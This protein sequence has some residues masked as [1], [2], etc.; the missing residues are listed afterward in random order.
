MAKE[1]KI[2]RKLTNLAGKVDA[3]PYSYSPN[4]VL[5]Q[6]ALPL[7][8]ILAIATRLMM[9]GQAIQ[10]QNTNESRTIMDL[11]K[12]QFILRIDSVLEN[13]EEDSYINRFPEFKEVQWSRGWPNDDKFQKLCSAGMALSDINSMKMD[14]Y[15]EALTYQPDTGEDDEMTFQLSLYDPVVQKDTPQPE[16]LHSECII[17]DSKRE[18]AMRH[19]EQRCL[20]WK[21]HLEYLQWSAVEKVVSQLPVGDEITHRNLAV[22]MKNLD[23]ELKNKGY[24]LLPVVSDEY[25]REGGS[26]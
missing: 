22:Q 19:I 1:K 25:N 5:V 12:Q 16:G 4:D 11:W 9:I 23:R 3:A 24:S 14:L 17:D 21:S 13:W 10:S 2:F 6:I 18:W 26:K 15:K 7:I 8:L 20:K